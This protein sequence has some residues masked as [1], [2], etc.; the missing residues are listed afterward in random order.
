MIH[1]DRKLLQDEI[2][3]AEARLIEVDDERARISRHI[4]KLK[5]ELS[6][7]DAAGEHSKPTRQNEQ[8]SGPDQL[9]STQ[10]VQLFM[11]ANDFGLQLL[12]ASRNVVE[13][14][15]LISDQSLQC[16]NIIG[17]LI[18]CNRH[19]LHCTGCTSKRPIKHWKNATVHAVSDALH[20][21]RPAASSVADRST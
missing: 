5:A 1:R 2:S 3:R 4:A 13:F 20:H 19:V 16:I 18:Q 21:S 7:L 12:I 6:M 10:K 8:P 15:C 14:C 11:E 17:Q 9:T